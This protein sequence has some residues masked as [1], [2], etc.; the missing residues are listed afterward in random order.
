MPSVRWR[1]F[2]IHI[3]YKL[4]IS[5]PCLSDVSVSLYSHSCTPHQKSSYVSLGSVFNAWRPS[6]VAVSQPP[7]LSKHDIIVFV[8]LTLCQPHRTELASCLHF[9]WVLFAWVTSF[10]YFSTAVLWFYC[11]FQNKMLFCSTVLTV[12]ITVFD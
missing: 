11:P 8:K 4:Q 2:T 9:E 10:I 7:L 1:V 3:D 5:Y 12:L 6:Q